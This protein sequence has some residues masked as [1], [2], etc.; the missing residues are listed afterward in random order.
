MDIFIFPK[1]AEVHCPFKMRPIYKHQAI[2]CSIVAQ[3]WMMEHIWSVAL[4][5]SKVI[6]ME[7]KSFIWETRAM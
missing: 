3:K 5:R 4:L 2:L 1:L 6:V 7:A